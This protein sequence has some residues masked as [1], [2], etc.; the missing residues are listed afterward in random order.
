MEDRDPNMVY[1]RYYYS[2]L[3]EDD[4][5][6]YRSLYEGIERLEGEFTFPK[7]LKHK[8][9][10]G[11]I[12]YFVGLDNP[13]IFY[14]DFNCF[15]YQETLLTEG[16]RVT[17]WYSP[18]DIALLKKKVQTVLGK[19]MSQISGK[20]AYEKEL[21]V[22]D[23][24]VRNIAYDSTAADH[25]RRYSPRANSIMGVLFYK[26]A[27]CEGISKT[28][29]LLLNLCGMKCVVA[30]GNTVEKGVG[31]AWNI[32]KIDNIPYHLDV[33]WD[34]STSLP[35][36]TSYSYFNLMDRD[37]LLDHTFAMNYP[38]CTQSTH[39][40]FV[41]NELIVNCKRDLI[42]VLSHARTRKQDVIMFHYT[43]EDQRAFEDLMQMTV[44]H[45]TD[46][47]APGAHF[48]VRKAINQEQHICYFMLEGKDGQL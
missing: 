35:S 6:V 39:N 7:S 13:H 26:T 48:S 28:V 33:T 5:K 36:F 18:E 30:Y 47:A 34:I 11:Q 19:M 31:H 23:L 3:P 17:Y 12:L 1:D 32:V 25:L 22:H 29:K 40:Y 10:L 42:R 21:S 15:D 20:D 44:Q 2:V 46:S 37:I 9:S 14:A 27:I 24:L 43:G 45:L 38:A 16:L 4:K 41:R 8:F